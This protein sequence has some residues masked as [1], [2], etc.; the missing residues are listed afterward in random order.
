M[1][2]TRNIID[3]QN[4][5]KSFKGTQVISG[6]DLKVK[7]GE[8][9]ALLGPNGAGKTTL[10]HM[11]STL[12][13]PDGGSAKVAGFD[14]V[15]EAKSVRRKISLT[16]QFAALDEAL[17]G[18]ENL[19]LISRLYGYSNKEASSIAMNLIQ[20]FNLEEATH[21]TLA[22][23][24]GGMRRRL[25]IAA[26]I[27]TRPDIIFLDEP[28]TGLDPQSRN[29][30]WDIVRS[31]LE[32]GTTV[33]LTTQYLEEADQL[34][35]QIAVINKGKIIAEGTPNELKESIGEKTLAL[36]LENESDQEKTAYILKS[37]FNLIVLK[38]DDPVV[39]RVQIKKSKLASE[40]INTL[41]A[42]NIEIA[43]F[44]LDQPSLDEV[45]LALTNSMTKET[46][47]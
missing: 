37:T 1:G 29:Q 38:E 19:I 10:I 25:D 6:I 15:Q 14:I 27:V 36:R 34:A 9:F 21:R 47:L 22:Q 8:L 7:S 24:S 40:V 20:I 23:Y 12:L 39:I 5:K 33:L 13:K 18:L 17:T 42:N 41:M 2:M 11:L 28:T 4:L 35:D 31:L 43:K 32:L 3:I 46:N 30:V 26:S 16:G 45:F 44:S